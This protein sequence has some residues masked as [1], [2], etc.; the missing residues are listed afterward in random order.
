MIVTRPWVSYRLGKFC[1]DERDFI[2]MG[3]WYL[4]A[5]F[6]FDRIIIKVAGNRT[7]IQ[8]RASLIL[9]LWFPW[10]NI[11]S[12]G[13]LDDVYFQSIRDIWKKLETK[14]SFVLTICIGWNLWQKHNY[15][16]VTWS[17]KLYLLYSYLQ[18]TILQVSDHCPLALLVYFCSYY[19]NP[20]PTH[21]HTRAKGEVSHESIRI[22][23]GVP[24][25]GH[26]SSQVHLWGK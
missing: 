17:F 20:P 26:F 3:K 8:V 19:L 2:L 10:P 4:H 11:L 22:C 16:M 13:V 12:S 9:G 23:D 18:L 5:T 7:G 14:D 15:V 6:I 24:F 1:A 21:T 25:S